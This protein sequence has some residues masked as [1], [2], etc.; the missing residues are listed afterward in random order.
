M[1]EGSMWLRRFFDLYPDATE[2]YTC[3]RVDPG[4]LETAV[5]A[6]GSDFRVGPKELEIIEQSPLWPHPSWYPKLSK[7]LDPPVSVPHDLRSTSQKRRLVIDL[8]ERLKHIEVVSV[9]LRFAWPDEFGIISPPVIALLSLTP[10]TG[11]DYVDH[12]M[13]YLSVLRELIRHYSESGLNRAADIDMALWSAAH[14][15]LEQDYA[16][17]AENMRTD[18]YFQRVRLENMLKGFGEKWGSSDW[19]QLVLASSILKHDAA[20]AALIAGKCYGTILQEVAKRAGVA[21]ASYDQEK[22]T[23]AFLEDK[24]KRK[25]RVMVALKVTPDDLCRWRRCRNDAIHPKAESPITKKRARDLIR[26]VELLLP[27]CD[28]LPTNL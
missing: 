6:V 12:Y 5:A 18:K 23:L 7:N 27:A 2:K 19:E 16:D 1:K 20:L 26:G 24:L 15:S 25:P 28:Q 9:L 10:V 4:T 14:L 3:K 21:S 11:E 17:L 8:W 13:R 22:D